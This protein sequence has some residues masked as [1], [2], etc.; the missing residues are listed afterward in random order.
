MKKNQNSDKININGKTACPITGSPLFSSH[1][2]NNV[3]IKDDYKIS[4]TKIGDNI[5]F[6]DAVGNLK[7]HD[8]DLFNNVINNFCINSSIDTPYVQI[9]NLADTNGRL[10]LSNIKKQMRYFADHQK[11]MVGLVLLNGPAWL[12]PFISQGMRYYKPTFRVTMEDS[13]PEA[14]GSAKKILEGKMENPFKSCENELDKPLKFEDIIFKSEWEYRN[15]ET[16]FKYKIGCIPGFLLYTSI[17]GTTQIDEDILNSTSLLEKIMAENQLSSVSYMISDYTETG[18]TS[19]QVRQ[20]YAKEIKR[21]TEKTNNLNVT[22]FIINANMFNKIA[23]RLFTTFVKRKY[24]FIDSIQDA[25]NKINKSKDIY[26][27]E[28]FPNGLSVTSSDLEELSNAFS[29]LQLDE[30]VEIPEIVISSDNP[31]SYLIESLEL[32]RNDLNELRENERTIQKERLLVGETTRKQML[33]MLE[34]AEQT[35]IAL[36][37]EEES[38]GIL[39]ENI[40]VGVMIVNP[41]TRIIENIN[42]FAAGLIGATKEE[43]IGRRCHSFVCPAM[44]QCCTI[45][46]LNKTVD[47]SDKTLLKLDG[48]SLP[49]LKTVKLIQLNGEEKI[50]ESFIDISEKKQAEEAFIEQAILQKHLME[51]SNT[52]I[53]VPIENADEAI[54]QSLADLGKFTNI[55]RSYIFMYDHEKRVGN[56]TYE[57]CNTGISPQIEELQE[58]PF[59]AIPDWIETHLAGKSMHIPDVFALDPSSGVRQILEPQEIKSLLALPMMNGNT[60]VG[61]VGFDAVKKHQQF[62]DKE[63]NLLEIFALMLVNLLNRIKTQS[64]LTIAMEKAKAGSKAKSEFLANM[65]HEIR[66]PLNGVIGFTDLLKNTPLNSVQ[67]Q[68]VD[69]ANVSGHTL[70]GIINDILDF[71]KIEAGM[72][73]LEFIKTDLFELLENSI[74]IVKYVSSKKS[75]EL[76]LN[77]DPTTP[78]FAVVDPIRLKQIL[79]NLLGNAVKFT[80]KGEVELKVTYQQIE[81]NKGKISFFVRDTGIGISEIQKEKLFKA[82]AQADSSTTRKFGGTGLGL[83]IS[84]MIAQKMESKIIIDSTPSIGSTFSFD[85]VTETEEGAKLNTDSIDKIKTC[86]IIDDNEN[87][88][89]ILEKMLNRWD[90]RCQTS[91]NGLTAIKTIE[92]SSQFDIII[93]DYNMPYID[94][95]KTIRLIREKLNLSEQIQ[96]IIL[97][98]SSSD[99]EVLH[100]KCEDL[101]VRFRLIKPVKSNDLFSYLSQIHNPVFKTSKE[102]TVE[103]TETKTKKTTN[104]IILIAEDVAMNMMMIKALLGKIEPNAE[105][106]EATTGSEAINLF[107]QTNPNLVFMD[108]QMP[109]MD[110]L[111]AAKEIRKIEQNSNNH[112]PIIAL[113]AG[114]FNEEK[115]RCIEA[116]MDDFLTKPIQVDKIQSVLDKYLSSR[117]NN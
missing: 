26:V 49:I 10:T 23:I 114:A 106:V 97:L 75:L 116:G 2:F 43:I 109:E 18:N 30:S 98:H 56:N 89:Q 38:K 95:L 66:T 82:F 102:K 117:I 112:V 94:G 70:L 48:S 8:L 19:I 88:R 80:D 35:K 64:E 71:S 5:L 50:L 76:L 13:Y 93:C 79:A 9:R 115:E 87:N 4:L 17:H 34:D 51:I 33:S 11:E 68:Y 61:F 22:Q 105:I 96:P 103:V 92:T 14:I 81:Q 37:K 24:V 52:F 72:L 7:N 104:S 27:E 6:I 74:D 55:D 110:G 20:L 41:E 62:S 54:N 25:F 44:D 39:L 77:I 32:V 100:K 99:D 78:R 59:D 31:L 46:D 36:K 85:I 65:S 107:L 101:G 47:N 67:Q 57:W 63:Q 16:N 45:C 69:N 83:I 108:V 84:D 28:D 21:I 12:K 111:D 91:D 90:I 53:N 15:H 42:T 73:H 58:I 60:C 3:L 86:L 113:T 29:I 1:K 40:S